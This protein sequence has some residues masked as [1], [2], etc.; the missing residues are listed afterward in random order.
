MSIRVF[1]CL[2]LFEIDQSSQK[3]FSQCPVLS[4]CVRAWTNAHV[5]HINACFTIAHAPHHFLRPLPESAVRT[6]YSVVRSP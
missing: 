5:G 3:P 1:S 4:S 2:Y 6:P